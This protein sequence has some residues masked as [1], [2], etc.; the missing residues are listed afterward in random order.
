MYPIAQLLNAAFENSPAAYYTMPHTERMPRTNIL[1][2]EQDY[3]IVADLPGVRNED[4]DIS[5]EDETLT[6]KAERSLDAPEGYTRRRAELDAKITFKRSFDL[7]SGVD[8]D[9]VSAK[10]DAGILTVTL[11]KSESVVPRRIEVK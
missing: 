3:L 11:P 6:I 7:G 4:L 2:R 5:L 8:T 10:L 1:E 9:K